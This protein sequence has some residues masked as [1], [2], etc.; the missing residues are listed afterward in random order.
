MV[1][2]TKQY[3]RR[4]EDKTNLVSFASRI[5]TTGFHRTESELESKGNLQRLI[6]GMNLTYNIAPNA[7]IGVTSTYTELSTDLQPTPR[8]DNRFYFRGSANNVVGVFGSYNW[9]NLSLFAEGARSR[10]GGH[11]LIAGGILSLSRELDI[12]WNFRKYEREFHSLYGSMFSEASNAAGERG[13]YLGLSYRP[14]SKIA[15]NGYWDRFSYP[16]M[17]Y[18]TF[19]PSDGYEGLLRVSYDHT[20]RSKI[21]AQVRRESKMRNLRLQSPVPKLGVGLKTNYLLNSDYPVNSWL[22]FKTRIQFSTFHFENN[23]TEGIAFMQD[24]TAT[25]KRLTISG[26]VAIFDTDDYENRQYSYEKDILYNFSIPAYSGQ[27][28][29][30]MLLL[31]YK[32]RRNL[33]FWVRVAQ[34]TLHDVDYIGNGYDRIAG[35]KRTEL[36]AQGRITF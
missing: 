20:K 19:G 9:K 33:S 23:I 13:L 5:L 24:F 34:T 8:L 27:G 4:K 30:T 7:R 26:R 36:K 18:Q 22:T 16:W 2:M 29:R 17:R 15:I 31:K 25:M 28:L 14:T 6:A 3:G 12:S 21:Y 35:N 1:S 32:A 10:S 11:G